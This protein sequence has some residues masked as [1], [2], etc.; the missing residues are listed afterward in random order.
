MGT[1]KRVFLCLAGLFAG[2]CGPALAA[3]QVVSVRPSLPSPQVVGTSV[4]WTVTATDSNPGPLTFQFNVAPPGGAAAMARDFNVGTLSSGIWTSQPFVWNPASCTN[5]TL[6]SGVVA[7]TCQPVE[8]VYQVQV[9]VK[10]F[11]SGETASKTV[12]FQVTPLATGGA[13]VAVGTANPLVALF[14]APSCAAGSAMRVLFQT[15]SRSAPATVTNWAPCRPPR[16]MTFEVAGMYPGTAYRMFSQT[17]TAGKISNGPPVSF[18]TG[19]LP[20]NIPFPSFK[21]RVPPGSQTDTADSVL[22]INPIQ[23]GTGPAFANVATDLSGNILWYYSTNPPQS[24]ALTRPLA[25]GTLLTFQ[26]GPTWNPAS[27]RMQLLRQ[28]DLAGN[29]LRETNTGIIQQ[30]LVAM[31]AT[32]GGPCDGFPSPPPAGSACLN[33]FSHD[34]IQTLPNGYTAL[35]ANVE[36]IF[37]AGTQGDT[38]GLPVDIMGNMIVV[39]DDNW[40]VVWYFDAFEHA[41]GPPQLDINRPP[42]LGETCAIKDSG[43]PPMF[44][45]GAGIA[46]LAHD[47]LHGNSLYYRP[48]DGSL[49]WSSRNQDWVMKIDYSNGAG[50]GN[51]LWRLGLDGD[52]TFNNIGNDP[53]PWFSAQHE[54]GMENNGAGPLTL[55]D[56]GNTR[57][58]PPPLGLGSGNSRGM[59]LTID[60]ANMQVTPVMS[61]D[62]GAFSQ[63]DGSAQLLSNGNYFFVLPLVFVSQS[64]VGSYSIEIFPTPGTLTGTQVLNLQGPEGYRGWRMPSLYNPPIT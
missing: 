24:I 12:Q 8:G 51:I 20:S 36:K 33:S 56:N 19:A 9:V 63:A 7:L 18:T 60:E 41:G 14:S 34:A 28:I 15:Q 11:A 58:S 47:W 26:A 22:L 57:V 52:F 1:A 3:I 29:I 35:L 16:T 43:C 32:D 49:L 23:F 64:T 61:A 21:L 38:S 2:L 54:A 27:N 45:L 39:L 44:L 13:P 48:Q 50:S 59:A 31:G 37:P 4:T 55:F 46:P 10:D 53:W 17:L 6:S 25:N 42:V 30:Q 62:L 5:V 40:R